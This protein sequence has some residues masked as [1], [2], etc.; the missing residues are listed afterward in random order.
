MEL[1]NGF[2]D[3][4]HYHHGRECGPGRDAA[5]EILRAAPDCKVE[6]E[7]GPDVGL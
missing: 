2:R 3:L 7:A 4:A 5:G 6:K 1:A